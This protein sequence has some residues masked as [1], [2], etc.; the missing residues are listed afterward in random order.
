MQCNAIRHFAPP[1]VQWEMRGEKLLVIYF[2][3]FNVYLW[4]G[5]EHSYLI[6]RRGDPKPEILLFM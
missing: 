5:G 3:D 4:N 1:K 2:L 6:S